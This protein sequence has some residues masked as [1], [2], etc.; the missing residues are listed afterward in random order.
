MLKLSSNPKITCSLEMD[1]L[2]ATESKM[3]VTNCLDINK[4]IRLVSKLIAKLKT[5]LN[6]SSSFKAEIDKKELFE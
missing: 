1:T 4:R 3:S 5:D 6:H 2:G